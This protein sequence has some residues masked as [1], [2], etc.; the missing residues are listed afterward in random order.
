MVRFILYFFLAIFF[1]RIVNKLF[2]PRKT[3]MPNDKDF[4]KGNHSKDQTIDY[5]DID[6]AKFED[7]ENKE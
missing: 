6:D 5:N 2:L 1:W 4:E 7:L 3:Q